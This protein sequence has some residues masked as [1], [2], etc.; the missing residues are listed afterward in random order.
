MRLFLASLVTAALLITGTAWAGGQ[1]E[2]GGVT[3]TATVAS[4][5]Y[6]E[7]PML[8]KMVAS[9][10]LPPGRRAAAGRADGAGGGRGRQLRRHL[11]RVRHQQ[12]ALERPD[13][14]AE[15][16]PDAAAHGPGRQDRPRRGQGLPAR[17]RQHELHPVPEGRHE[18]VGRRAVHRARLHV[19]VLRHVQAGRGRDLGHPFSD[20][21]RRGGRRLH[22]ALRVQPPVPGVPARHGALALQ[23]LD[24]VQPQALP[25]QV[26]HHVQRGC[27][28]G[29]Q[30][31][32]LRELGR[33]V[34]QS[35]QFPAYP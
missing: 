10:E 30:G 27:Q 24:A 7:A 25:E 20:R 2:G 6:K 8:A 17:P 1:E 26:P 19:Q 13:R 21:Q 12:L 22:G 35:R 5:T 28:Y 34:Q 15:P 3:T 23:R 32:G 4:G 29:R 33:G 16:R 31:G 9:G 14:G 11:L 18:V